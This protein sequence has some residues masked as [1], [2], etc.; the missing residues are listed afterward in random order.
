MRFAIRIRS[1]VAT[2]MP[3]IAAN[4]RRSTIRDTVRVSLG[5]LSP[6]TDGRVKTDS[7]QVM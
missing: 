3:R 7:E 5:A 2:P 6:A 1:T 4:S